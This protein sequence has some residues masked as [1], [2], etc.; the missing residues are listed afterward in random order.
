MNMKCMFEMKYDEFLRL[1]YDVEKN[2]T[3][4]NIWL[5]EK[6]EVIEINDKTSVW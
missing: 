6:K 5:L 1:K 2:R 3:E 4:N